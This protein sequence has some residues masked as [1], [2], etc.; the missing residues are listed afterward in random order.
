MDRGLGWAEA[1][2][3]PVFD[4]SWKCLWTPREE[5]STGRK[6]SCIWGSAMG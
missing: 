5:K 2:M 6:M 4:L 1:A 3:S